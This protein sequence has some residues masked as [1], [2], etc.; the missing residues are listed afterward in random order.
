MSSL[1]I[2]LYIIIIV[3]ITVNIRQ[4]VTFTTIH[5]THGVKTS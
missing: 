5:Q 4:Q 1:Y 2:K 3:Q